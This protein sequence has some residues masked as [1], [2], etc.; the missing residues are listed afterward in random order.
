MSKCESCGRESPDLIPNGELPPKPVFVCDICLKKLGKA[1]P[2]ELWVVIDPH[3][4]PTGVGTSRDNAWH[5]AIPKEWK[6]DSDRFINAVAI[7]LGWRCFR[8]AYYADVEALERKLEVLEDI[9]RVCDD[10]QKM[11]SRLND[12]IEDHERWL[13]EMVT[14]YKLAADDHAV[15]RRRAINEMIHSLREQVEFSKILARTAKGNLKVSLGDGA[16]GALP[17]GQTDGRPESEPRPHSGDRCCGTCARWIKSGRD[18]EG[19]IGSCRDATYR[20]RQIV[21]Y[22]I[23]LSVSNTYAWGG[24]DCPGFEAKR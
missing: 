6:S 9:D 16:T 22:A 5:V 7:S 17:A 14:D 11:V 18:K 23:N 13:K 8:V 10:Q 4:E 1:V 21:P 15:S 3:G 12:E 2:E 20:A 19:D 24:K